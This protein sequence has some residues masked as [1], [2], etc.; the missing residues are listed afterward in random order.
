MHRYTQAGGK[1]EGTEFHS[2]TL[3]EGMR[4]A[5]AERKRLPRN[6]RRVEEAMSRRDRESPASKVMNE[7]IELAIAEE[8]H[9]PEQAVFVNA[10][11]PY[12]DHEIDWAAREGSSVVLVSSNGDVQIIAADEIVQGVLRQRLHLPSQCGRRG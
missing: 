11:T 1:Q 3:G 5:I 8:S 4:I 10:D 7:A 2:G 12:T 6:D 9:Y